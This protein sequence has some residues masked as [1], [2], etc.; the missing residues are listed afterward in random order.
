MLDPDYPA[1]LLDLALPPPVL[2]CLGEVPDRPA[3][4]IVG[5]RAA[6]AYGREAATLFGRELARAG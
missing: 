5:S 6:D 2:Y 1:P 4:A 3:T